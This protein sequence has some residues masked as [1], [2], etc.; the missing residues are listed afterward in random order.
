MSDDENIK[1]MADLLK[2]GA[3][4]LEHHCPVC[5][6]PL[7]MINEEIWCPKCNKRVVIVNESE[8]SLPASTYSLNYLERVLLLKIQETSEYI[9]NETDIEKLRQLSELVLT[10]LAALERTYKIQ[11]V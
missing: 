9:S 8:P 11:K 10:L 5:S 3:T 2:S 7:F 4:M 6:L 1:R